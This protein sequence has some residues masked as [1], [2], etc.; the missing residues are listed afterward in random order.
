MGGRR[1]M[2]TVEVKKEDGRL[3]F[4]LDGRLD[5]ITTPQLEKM[6]HENINGTK[7]LILECAKLDYVSSAGLRLLLATHNMIKNTGGIMLLRDVN[8][9]I[10]DVL[11]M[12]GF[13][14]ILHVEWM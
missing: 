13:S 10:K 7:E 14:P 4:I 5:T 1:D 2:L 6:I 3:I 8:E 9:G 12:T 11:D